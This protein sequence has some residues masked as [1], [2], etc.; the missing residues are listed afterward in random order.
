MRASMAAKS[1]TGGCNLLQQSQKLSS[2]T[3]TQRAAPNVIGFW[4]LEEAS[5]AP[6]LKQYWR[7]VVRREF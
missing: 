2:L 6:P 5:I 7:G 3:T 1:Q 4:T